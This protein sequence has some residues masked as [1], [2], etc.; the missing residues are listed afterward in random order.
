MPLTVKIRKASTWAGADQG[1][2]QPEA[3]VASSRIV[4]LESG[5]E[6]RFRAPHDSQATVKLLSGTAEKDGTELAPGHIYTF[7]GVR[8]KIL[9]WQRCELE[10]EGQL[11]FESTSGAGGFN[12]SANVAVNLHAQLN[13]RRENATRLGTEGPRILIAGP[14]SVGKSTLART[15]TAYATKQGYQPIVVNTDPADGI[16][17]LPGTL[18]AA[19]FATVMD[20]EAVGE[21][22]GGT[23]TSG[24]ST[25]PVKLPL[26]HC[27]GLRRPR[28][29]A[30]VYRE[31]VSGLASAVSARLSGVEEVKRS[32]VI[33]DSWGVDEQESGDFACLAHIIEEM[34]SECFPQVF[35]PRSSHHPCSRTFANTRVLIVN[36][37]VVIG[38]PTLEQSM[39]SKF[40]NET[41]S[42]GEEINIVQIEKPEGVAGPDE[43]FQQHAREQ[44]IKEYFFGDARRAL[45]PQIQ[46]MDFDG[47][48]IYRTSG[49]EFNF[50][51]WLFFS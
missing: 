44:V 28:D 34:S 21:G 36:I 15:L 23:P 33:V 37:V 49:R 7:S 9:S 25:V 51:L 26:V 2:S 47:L 3:A 32:G 11:D 40:A 29:D 39:R 1:L 10:I 30:D 48:V 41:T 4:T 27:Y 17:T 45:S 50:Y 12:R 42:L 31:M 16:L 35:S 18:S 8:S 43:V 19:V 20:I 6:W 14:P 22:W 5:Q 13:Q 38:S 46:Q 24:P